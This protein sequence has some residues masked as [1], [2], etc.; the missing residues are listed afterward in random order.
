MKSNLVQTAEFAIVQG[1]DH[2]PAFNWWVEHMLKKRDRITA[3]FR[4]WQTRYFSRSHKYGIE[5]LTTVEQACTTHAK[6]NDT[7]WADAIFKEMENVRG[8]FEVLPNVKFIPI[9]HQ[10]L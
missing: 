2:E 4:K 1:V 6:N 9:G 10:F 3:S 7:L 5:L 8:A